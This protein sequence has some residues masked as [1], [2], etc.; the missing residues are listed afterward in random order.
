VSGSRFGVQGSKV[1]TDGCGKSITI[2]VA[3][4][5]ELIITTQE[6]TDTRSWIL[7][8]KLEKERG[9]YIDRTVI[10]IMSHLKTLTK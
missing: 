5:K 8:K 3:F 7:D 1:T 10:R 4:A 9:G 2:C 6:N